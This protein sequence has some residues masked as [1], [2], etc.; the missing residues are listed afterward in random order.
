[1]TM[2]DLTAPLGQGP[3]RHRRVITV[4]AAKIVAIALALFLGAFVLW[5]VIVQD[6]LGGEP[7]AVAPADLR[8][9]KKPPAVIAVPKAAAAIPQAAA[10]ID[11]AAP[12]ATVAPPPAPPLKSPSGV[13]VTIV[14]G[15]T[16][17]KREIVVAPPPEPTYAAE[18][19]PAADQSDAQ[20]TG[21]LPKRR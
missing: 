7:V 9:A 16:G 21:Q 3:K 5:A 20:T 18:R 12:P 17:A 2:N 1:M 14:D 15:R 6:R 19:T 8:I 13:T 4:P 10:A 11:A